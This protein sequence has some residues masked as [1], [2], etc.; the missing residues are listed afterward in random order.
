MDKK[1]Y[2]RP[3]TEAYKMSWSEPLAGLSVDK[4]GSDSG[5]GTPESRSTVIYYNDDQSPRFNPWKQ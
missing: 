5:Y 2:I 3:E 1:R 4:G